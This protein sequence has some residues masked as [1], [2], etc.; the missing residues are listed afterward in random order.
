MALAGQAPKRT[1]FADYGTAV[2][3]ALATAAAAS[4]N[5]GPQPPGQ[6]VAEIGRALSARILRTCSKDLGV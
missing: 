4:I 3:R 1:T 5:P 6:F 2:S